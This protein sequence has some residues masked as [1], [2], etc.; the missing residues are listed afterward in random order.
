MFSIMRSVLIFFFFTATL[1]PALTRAQQNGS[2]RV[3]K[4]G[5]FAP[6]YLDSVFNSSGQFRYSNGIPKFMAPALDFV[7]GVQ[8]GLDSLPPGDNPIEAYIFDTRSYKQPLSFLVKS[9]KL[10]SLDLIIS[11]VKDVEYR[12]LA[13]FALSRHI[14]F[15]S[16]A[17]PNDGGVKGNPFVVIMNSTLRAHC[18][19]IFGFILQ[20]H[21]TDKILLCRKKGQQED[22]VASYLK[23]INEQDG[24]PIVNIQTLQFDSTLSSELLAKKLDSTRGNILIGGSLDENFAFGLSHACDE[25]DEKY[26][27]T[28]IGMPNWD[29]FKSLNRKGEFANFPIYFTTPYF[30]SKTDAWSRMLIEGYKKKWKGY[31]SDMAFKGF[32]C[33]LLF[34]RMLTDHPGSFINHLN[35]PKYQIFTEYNFKPVNNR[36]ESTVPDYFENKHLY[37]VKLLNGVASKAW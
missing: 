34:V 33:A 18:E 28:L 11:P 8:T 30:N 27:I 15:I 6:L 36:S 29:G 23:A 4:V 1:F 35:D 24:K 37:F 2:P 22:R 19:A 16:A 32:E 10:D 7:N 13:D 17:Y 21:G 12:L 26:P 25:L 9:R 5:I 20:N 3:F 14:P 31:P